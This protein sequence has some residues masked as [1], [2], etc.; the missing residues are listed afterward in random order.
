[1]RQKMFAVNI[2][3]YASF[4]FKGEE[5][6]AI[7]SLLV[8]SAFKG[9]S[10]IWIYL[11]ELKVLS[12]QQ[13]PFQALIKSH[14][15]I[16]RKLK[17]KN[18]DKFKTLTFILTPECF[19]K[20]LF[21]NFKVILSEATLNDIYA[22]VLWDGAVHDHDVEREERE[23]D[24]DRLQHHPVED[25]SRLHLLLHALVGNH[26]QICSISVSQILVNRDDR[27]MQSYSPYSALFGQSSARPNY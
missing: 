19:A 6:F 2:W 7:L 20:C 27:A 3:T 18:C 21:L 10:Y 1:M 8:L 25:W 15:D 16:Q 17:S 5:C 11:L 26:H 9:S 22:K 13:T 4:N 14:D 24:D 23:R 12:S